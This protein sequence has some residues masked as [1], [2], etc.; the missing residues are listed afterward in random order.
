MLRM[1]VLEPQFIQK[2][3][4]T[5]PDVMI[6]FWTVTREL[7]HIVDDECLRGIRLTLVAELTAFKMK[8]DSFSLED[9]ETENARAFWVAAGY[10]AP[11]LK[12]LA[13]HVCPL[14]C[15]SSEAECN[16]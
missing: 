8:T 2:S 14:P 5:S 13:L 10:H 7:L 1:H 11:V 9:Y 4:N 16:W 15:A 3:K 12:N 6:S